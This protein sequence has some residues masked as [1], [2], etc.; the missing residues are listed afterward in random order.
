MS[1]IRIDRGF[2]DALRAELVAHVAQSRGARRRRAWLVA[3]AFAGIGLAGGGIAVA[4]NLFPLP[5][6]DVVTQQAE[7]VTETHTGTATVELGTPPEDATHI[8]L[9]LWCLT[10]GS[11]W[12]PDGAE[13]ICFES[14]MGTPGNWSG[15]TLPLEN[16]QHSV[17]IT[18]DSGAQWTL[19][20]TYV[21][22]ET[23]D[24]AVNEN[25]D[26]YGVINENGEPDLIAVSATNGRDGYAYAAD[27]N[28]P[29]PS[30]PEE[31]TTWNETHGGTRAVPVYESDGETVIG[32]FVIGP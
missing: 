9:E 24:W 7:T 11:F 19:A 3:G 26:T 1:T 6:G 13:V 14:E 20:A 28:G 8:D 10:P 21:D 17:T 5:G 29:M 2:S 23:T 16:G 4:T 22:R 15:Y 31:A 27:L 25:G 30:S 18:A 32:E 12:F